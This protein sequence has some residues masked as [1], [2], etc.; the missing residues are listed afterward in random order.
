MARQPAARAAAAI[1][2]SLKLPVDLVVGN[3][4][5]YTVWVDSKQVLDKAGGDFPSDDAVVKAV[6]SALPA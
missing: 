4:G 5:E 2:Q 6:K 3:S 1:K